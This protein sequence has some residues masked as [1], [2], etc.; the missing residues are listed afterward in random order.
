MRRHVGSRLSQL[1]PGD[2]A[3]VLRVL[4][5]DPRVLRELTQLGVTPGAQLTLE[6]SAD[7]HR[8]RVDGVTQTLSRRLASAIVVASARP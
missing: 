1:A 8:I 7:A 3:V 5:Q 4:D 2:T 6:A